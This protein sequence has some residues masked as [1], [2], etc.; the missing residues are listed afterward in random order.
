MLRHTRQ[1]KSAKAIPLK[2]SSVTFWE[3][4]RAT[5]SRKR[6]LTE[7]IPVP[8]VYYVSSLAHPTSLRHWHLIQLGYTRLKDPFPTCQ[9]DGSIGSSTLPSCIT[10]PM[11]YYISTE[12]LLKLLQVGV[13]NNDRNF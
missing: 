12:Q 2:R 8:G 5:W 9:Y 13:R 10:A 11:V 6:G 3:S 7:V 1:M 4:N